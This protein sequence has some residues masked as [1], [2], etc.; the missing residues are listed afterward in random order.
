VGYVSSV[1]C[2]WIYEEITGK[3][4]VLQLSGPTLSTTHM[5]SCKKIQTFSD[6]TSG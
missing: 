4:Y 3:F 2:F 6:P 1:A 5:D